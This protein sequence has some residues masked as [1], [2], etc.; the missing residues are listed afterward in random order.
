[1]PIKD[2]FKAWGHPNIR[3][4]HKTTLMVTKDTELTHHGDC[5]VSVQAEKGLKDLDSQLKETIRNSNAMV[6]LV[7]EVEGNTFEISGRGDQRLSLSH[8]TD[9]VVRKSSYICNRTLMIHADRA[10]CDLDKAIVKLLQNREQVVNITI[11][12]EIVTQMVRN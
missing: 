8:P 11:S 9:I 6:R 1:M 12:V 10:A 5:V 2:V 4:R 7:I 3:P